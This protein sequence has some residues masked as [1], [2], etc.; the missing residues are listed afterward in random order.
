MNKRFS[1]VV[2]AAGE[3][4]RIGRNKLELMLGD[5]SVLEHVIDKFQMD[6]VYE[7]VVVTGKFTAEPKFKNISPPIRFVHNPDY[8][9]GMG[10]SVKKGLESFSIIPDAVFITPADMPAIRKETIHKMAV[11]F[12]DHNIVIPTYQGKKGH[13]VMLD[14]VYIEPCL[15][16]QKEKVLYEVIEKNKKRIDF[17]PVEDEGILMDID[18]MED[19]ERLKKHID[20]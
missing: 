4:S 2:L 15:Q 11:A 7:I 18:T 1:T 10:S 20:H 6:S 8:A 12:K 13:P 19:Y 16:E 3:S 14:K 9:Q 5:R 17:I